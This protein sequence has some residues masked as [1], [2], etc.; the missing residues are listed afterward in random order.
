MRVCERERERSATNC[1][2]CVRRCLLPR[3]LQWW[4]LKGEGSRRE[5]ATVCVVRLGWRGLPWPPSLAGAGSVLR[6]HTRTSPLSMASLRLR[7]PPPPHLPP[8]MVPLVCPLPWQHPAI[9]SM[10]S[11]PSR[12]FS[13]THLTL[14]LC[15]W[16]IVSLSR[17][18]KLKHAKKVL[19]LQNWC[20]VNRTFNDLL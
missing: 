2:P 13:A 1:C 9:P 15:C 10:I 20:C 5:G 3:H 6:R 19:Q 8:V 7:L 18:L 4:R 14:K 11:L 16:G 17:H 12:F